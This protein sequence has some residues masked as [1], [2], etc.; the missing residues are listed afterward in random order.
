MKK[1]PLV[2]VVIPTYNAAK[3]LPQAVGSALNQTYRNIEVIV[4]DDGSTDG[5]EDLPILKDQRVHYFK[6]PH[7]GGPATPRNVGIERAKG[8]L[9]AFLD[10]DDIWLPKKIEGQVN[11]IERKKVDL[12]YCDG[13]VANERD[14]PVR[15]YYHEEIPTPQGDVFRELY[16]TNF[17]PTSSV[18]VRKGCFAK[19]GVFDTRARFVGVEDYELW[20]RM[21]KFFRFGY[22]AKVLFRYRER[23]GSISDQGEFKSYESLFEILRKHYWDALKLGGGEVKIKLWE[24][25]KYLTKLSKKE[26]FSTYLKYKTLALFYF[27]LGAG[28]K[29]FLLREAKAWVKI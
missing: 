22:L 6:I 8:E 18:L 16:A 19:I 29:R 3:F 10:A 5:T 11:L 17:I 12:V 7:S 24:M 28:D 14:R 1:Q 21:A 26:N 25:G 23:A 15:D 2:S 4:V 20:L 27:P 13:Q 9:I